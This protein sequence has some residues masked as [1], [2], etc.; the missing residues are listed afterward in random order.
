MPEKMDNDSKGIERETV[1]HQEMMRN[2]RK[3]SWRR[4]GKVD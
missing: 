1:K 4:E 3:A 2:L